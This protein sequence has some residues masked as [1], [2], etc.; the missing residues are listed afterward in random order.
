[1]IEG[2]LFQ[3]LT[4]VGT[5]VL[6]HSNVTVNRLANDHGKHDSHY[7][8]CDYHPVFSYSTQT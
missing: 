8:Q 4:S 6:R 2:S 1:M 7:T 3:G 5:R